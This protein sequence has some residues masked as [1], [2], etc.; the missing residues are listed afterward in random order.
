M[1]RGRSEVR[2][3]RRA[4][5]VSYR[6]T[7]NVVEDFA[8]PLGAVALSRS[9]WRPGARRLPAM[10]ALKRSVLGP[11]LPA[12]TILPRLPGTLMVT[13][14][15]AESVKRTVVPLPARKRFGCRLSRVSSRRGCGLG[16]G[17]GPGVGFG[18]GPGVGPGP[19]GGAGFCERST[20]AGPQ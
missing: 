4:W 1:R 11:G 9:V 10:R 13:R 7:V 2:V 20:S 5:R 6:V 8:E 3:V 15:G 12:V 18:P 19:G 14:A 17:P 16:W